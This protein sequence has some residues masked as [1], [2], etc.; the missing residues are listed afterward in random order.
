LCSSLT[1]EHFIIICCFRCEVSP[2]PL[3]HPASGLPSRCELQIGWQT[4]AVLPFAY[5]LHGGCYADSPGLPHVQI[6]MGLRREHAAATAAMLPCMSRWQLA[7]L[8]RWAHRHRLASAV[9][10]SDAP[11]A[12]VQS[13]A[14]ARGCAP[15]PLFA[16]ELSC[17]PWGTSWMAVLLFSLAVHELS[18]LQQSLSC[19]YVTHGVMLQIMDGGAASAE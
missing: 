10:V 12:A 15:A 19:G 14:A 6:S 18:D 4:R 1:P 17:A 2:R 16:A 9:K 8:P 11:A 7:D 3:L 5:V 13:W